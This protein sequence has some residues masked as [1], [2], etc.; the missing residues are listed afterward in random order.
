MAGAG[1]DSSCWWAGVVLIPMSG[2][3]SSTPPTHELEL[4]QPVIGLDFNGEQLAVTVAGTVAYG[5][6]IFEVGAIPYC[7]FPAARPVPEPMGLSRQRLAT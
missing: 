6:R 1:R 2:F 3:R 5:P 7:W 4:K